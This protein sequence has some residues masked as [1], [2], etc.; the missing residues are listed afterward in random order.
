MPG[1]STMTKNPEIPM[2]SIFFSEE[3]Q[4]VFLALLM[5]SIAA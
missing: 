2:K 4:V 5:V 1:I 3:R